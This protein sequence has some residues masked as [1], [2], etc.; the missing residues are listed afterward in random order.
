MTPDRCVTCGTTYNVHRS[1]IDEAS[2]CFHCYT[3]SRSNPWP[4]FTEQVLDEGFY[5][6]ED[7]LS[8]SVRNSSCSPKGSELLA[9]SMG[10]TAT[11]GELFGCPVPG[12]TH[13]AVFEQTPLGWQLYCEAS[14]FPLGL[15]E[16]RAARAYGRLVEITPI[17]CA[18]WREKLNFE[19]GRLR[20]RPVPLT[21]PEEWRG[22][23][24]R[25][26]T[27]AEGWALYVGLRGPK[28]DGLPYVWSCRFAGAYSGVSYKVAW[29]ATCEMEAVGL[30]RRGPELKVPGAAAGWERTPTWYPALAAVDAPEPPVEVIVESWAVSA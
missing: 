6:E 22:R 18:R 14:Q 21:I 16:L 28:M 17:E 29:R 9:A 3:T 26:R 27:V 13:E 23:K 5:V 30:I 2:Y 10:I 7:L 25:W 15:A 1:V 4:S 12:H 24:A 20:P 8:P 19:A 11:P